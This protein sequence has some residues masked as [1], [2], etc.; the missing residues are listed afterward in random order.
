MTAT[1]T[2]PKNPILP[3]ERQEMDEVID[4][5]RR[6]LGA[7]RTFVQMAEDADDFTLWCEHMRT[8][9]LIARGR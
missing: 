4:C 5:A 8:A 9:W 2:K 3:S 7:V 6:R 1:T